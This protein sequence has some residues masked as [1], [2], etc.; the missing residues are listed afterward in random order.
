[1]SSKPGAGIN[2]KE[3]G[4]TSE[5]LNVF[6][7]N[8]LRN[9]GIDPTKERFTVKMTGGP[10][11][12][13][14]G[15]ELKILH[16]EYG[17][18]PRVVAIAD[19]FGAAFD[20]DGLNWKELMRLFKEG[21]SIAEFNKSMLSGHESAYVI[22]ADT[23]ENILKRNE[24]P[25]ATQ[26]DIFIPA[27]GRPYTV[28]EK[29]WS[30]FIGPNGQPTCKAIVEGA[31]I[32]FTSEARE[33]LQEKG[34]LIIKDSSANKT[35]VICSSYEII[36]GLTL[37]QDEFLEIKEE[38]VQQVIEILRL[39]ADQEA[40]LLFK[41]YNHHGGKKT[42]VE[43][44]MEISREI[45]DVTDIVLEELTSNQEEVLKEPFYQELVLTHC[46]AI[47]VER[48]RDR[49]LERLPQAHQIAI[50]A[51][52]IASYIVYREGLGWLDGIPPT[53]RFEAAN[54]Y[55]QQDILTGKLI[56]EVMNSS[57]T[58]KEKI[59]AILRKSAARDLTLLEM[60]KR[61]KS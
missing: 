34:V 42:L 36:G 38:Y 27:G 45:N 31:N 23:P 18:N 10:D 15:N 24:V 44:S 58:D 50:L 59:A 9:I 4:V 52:Y 28:N 6:V 54:T 16:R 7:G 53:D 35:G 49:I 17:E 47:L 26:A 12:D 22:K 21:Q 60:E 25:F 43:L 57:F 13:V 51:A 61:L 5:G 46:P 3:Y 1:M 32:Y 11:G 56:A 33:A 40:K 30:N 20:P 37:S 29:N 2:H 19:G 8:M 39:R 55:M 48:Y 14:A 41:E